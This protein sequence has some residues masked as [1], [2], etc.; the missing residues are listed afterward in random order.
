M[1]RGY[2]PGGGSWG[3]QWPREARRGRPVPSRPVP[4]RPVPSRTPP[5]GP[6]RCAEA[7][8]MRE[9]Q[10]LDMSEIDFSTNLE[11]SRQISKD[12][13]KA[14]QGTLDAGGGQISTNLDKSRQ[15]STNLDRARGTRCGPDAPLH[16]RPLSPVPYPP[17]PIP[18]PHT[19]SPS[20]IPAL[21]PRAAATPPPRAT[22]V[23]RA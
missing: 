20:P 3:A 22:D 5:P 1:R 18:R 23:T 9:E 13:D 16:P 6:T 21:P 8:A 10:D 12:L 19:P 4:S 14:R 17:S 15:I 2:A 11:R 7:A